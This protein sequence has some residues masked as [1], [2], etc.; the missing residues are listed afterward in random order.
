[1]WLANRLGYVK[2]M[3]LQHHTQRT[4]GV[5]LMYIGIV[6]MIAVWTAGEFLIQPVIFGLGYC[7]GFILI[8][9]LPCVNRKLATGR[10]TT[11]QNSMDN[12]A[13]TFNIIFCSL[14]GWMIGISDLRLLWLSVL[15]VVGLHFLGFY[16]SQGKWIVVL[17]VLTVLNALAGLIF[18]EI[19]FLLVG[20][21]DGV[22][23]LLF[24]IKL[25]SLRT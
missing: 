4:C 21:L 10:Q 23:K 25:F 24:G 15:L 12:L 9:V 13:V 22:L 5:W 1:M 14:C 3:C 11:F 20:T 7:F 18:M 19:P 2:G 17:G 8:L 6:I 16:F